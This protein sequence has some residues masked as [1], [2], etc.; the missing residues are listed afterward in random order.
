MNLQVALN[1]QGVLL[2]FPLKGLSHW[3]GSVLDR[4]VHLYCKKKNGL[5]PEKRVLSWNEKKMVLLR[6]P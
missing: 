4:L 6:E 2:L 5:E 3:Q 1:V